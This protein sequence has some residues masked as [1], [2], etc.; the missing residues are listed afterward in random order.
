MQK[1]VIRFAASATLLALP[2]AGC[3]STP[4]ATGA[5]PPVQSQAVPGQSAAAS[6]APSPEDN[7]IPAEALLQPADTGG[8]EAGKL[9]EGEFAHVRPLRPC[10]DARYPSDASRTDAVAM[11]YLIPGEQAGSVPAGVVVEFVGR[12]RAGGAAEQF[13]DIKAAIAKCPGGLG[14]GQHKWEIVKSDDGFMVVRISQKYSYADEAPATVSTFAAV[15]RVG[16]AIVVVT[17]N[18]W[19]NSGGDQ[20]LVE[21]L[22]AKAEKRAEVIG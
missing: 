10:G 20:A 11:R 19:E 4:A 7:G 5:S 15:S 12:H 21:D 14:K 16:E 13:T 18:G 9:A 22:I 8:A 6:A 2:L 17:D 1:N 3:D